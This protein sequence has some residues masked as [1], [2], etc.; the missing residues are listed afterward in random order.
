MIAADGLLTVDDDTENS[1][2]LAGAGWLWLCRGYSNVATVLLLV[3]RV[4]C[5][6]RKV[7]PS[8]EDVSTVRR[9]SA[10]RFRLCIPSC[11]RGGL[12]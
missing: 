6:Q 10:L 9:E 3:V 8:L 12:L 4:S 1:G 5:R 2:W 11:I 7:T